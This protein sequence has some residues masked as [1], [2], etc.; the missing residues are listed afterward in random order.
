MKFS[1]ITTKYFWWFKQKKFSKKSFNLL[2]PTS[3]FYI[4][5]KKPS[6]HPLEP[7]VWQSSVENF[8]AESRCRQ[9]YYTTGKVAGRS[10]GPLQPF[11]KNTRLGWWY[12]V[13]CLWWRSLAFA[14]EN[15]VH[16]SRRL[17]H[18][19]SSN[20]NS[21]FSYTYIYTTLILTIHTYFQ[22]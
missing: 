2:N 17:K 18:W 16:N 12:M 3:I 15:F 5:S 11:P 14:K 8:F 9:M 19:S 13:A 7:K 4:T 10:T 6:A 22:D 21:S 1:K 20:R